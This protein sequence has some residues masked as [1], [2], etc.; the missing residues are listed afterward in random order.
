MCNN[1]LPVERRRWLRPRIYQD[2]MLCM[3]RIYNRWRAPLN[4]N[5]SPKIE[6]PF[7]RKR[8]I[9]MSHMY[10]FRNGMDTE[11]KTTLLPVD[12]VFQ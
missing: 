8:L 1:Y 6:L 7:F 3:Q 12:R 11:N 10:A 4:V 2:K 9:D 5:F